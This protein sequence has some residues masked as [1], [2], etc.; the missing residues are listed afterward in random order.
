MTTTLQVRCK[1][2][3]THKTHSEQTDYSD[4]FVLPVGLSLHLLLFRCLR[5]K[6]RHWSWYNFRVSGFQRAFRYWRVWYW[7]RHG[8]RSHLKT[9]HCPLSIARCDLLAA[10]FVMLKILRLLFATRIELVNNG[11]L[12]PMKTKRTTEAREA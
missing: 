11:C 8:K 2:A 5:H 9:Q 7:R 4:K 3:R 6:G 1:Q 10:I 12:T